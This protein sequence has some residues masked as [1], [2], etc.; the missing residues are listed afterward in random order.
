MFPSPRTGEVLNNTKKSWLKVLKRA[1]ITAFRWHDMRHHF[2]SRLVQAGVD[3]YVVKDLLGHASV[4]TT[5]KHY[6]HL[7]PKRKID[8]VAR[9]VPGQ[10][11]V[12][13]FP[14]VAEQ[15]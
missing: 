3:L 14:K 10:R 8:A 13:P 15:A 6:A 4:A 5:E 2:A 9:L 12:V 7:A 11:N 1:G